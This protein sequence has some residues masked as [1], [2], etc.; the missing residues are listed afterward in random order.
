M[1]WTKISWKQI[2]ICRHQLNALSCRPIEAIVWHKW[3]ATRTHNFYCSYAHSTEWIQDSLNSEKK[4]E[5]IMWWLHLCSKATST[6]TD[7]PKQQQQQQMRTREL[8]DSNE[9]DK[10]AT[11]SLKWMIANWLDRRIRNKQT[12]MSVP[13]CSARSF[14]CHRFILFINISE[15][16][17]VLCAVEF[18]WHTKRVQASLGQVISFVSKR[19]VFFYFALLFSS[20]AP[21]RFS[22]L[23]S[24]TRHDHWSWKCGQQI[25]FRFLCVVVF[26]FFCCSSSS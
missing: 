4:P 20:S 24:D 17:T 9:S 18:D 8:N 1:Q 10:E 25:I 14:S 16:I 2:I 7:H 22:S 19:C 11:N 5:Y 26:L 12:K 23:C 21:L 15:W 3:Q 6:V 13:I